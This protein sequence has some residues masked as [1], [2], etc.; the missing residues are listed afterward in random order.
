MHAAGVTGRPLDQ[1]ITFEMRAQR[2]TGGEVDAREE[3]VLTDRFYFPAELA[4]MLERAGFADVAVRG[5]YED[6]EPTAEDDF[7][8]FIA[9]R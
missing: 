7:M 8:V 5:G 4:L 6:E 9:R 2:L 3:Y 1:R